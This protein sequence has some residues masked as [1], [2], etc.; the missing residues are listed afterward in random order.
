MQL[1]L[2]LVGVVDV[3]DVAVAVA[4]WMP[5]CPWVVCLEEAGSC[6]VAFVGAWSSCLP[7]GIQHGNSPQQISQ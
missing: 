6:Q 3:V 7:R 1:A 5:M 2:G 4:P